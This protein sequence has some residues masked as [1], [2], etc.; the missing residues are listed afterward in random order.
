MNS[1]SYQ[2]LKVSM[3]ELEEL[4][5]LSLSTFI[6]TFSKQ[7]NPKDMEAYL[8]KAFNEAQLKAELEHPDSYFY[9]LKNDGKTIGY[10]KLNVKKAQTDQ[11]LDNALEIERIYIVR[12]HQDQ[13]FGSKL[14]DFAIEEAKRKNLMCIW[15]G[16]WEKNEKAITFYKRYGLEVFA[17]H[18]FKLGRDEQRDLLMKKVL[19]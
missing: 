7:N 15:L 11:V 4:C 14:M 9:F 2:I 16:V 5:A 10:L 8:K 17:D 3:A 13:G 1:G 18:P 12:S 19:I 6:D